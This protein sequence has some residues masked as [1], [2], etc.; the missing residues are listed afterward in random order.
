MNSDAFVADFAHVAQ[1]QQSRRARLR[2]HRDGGA[3][4][5]GIGVVGIVDDGAPRRPAFTCSRPATARNAASPSRRPPALAP[6]R[7]AAAAAAER[8]RRVVPS[9]H[10]AARRSTLPCGVASSRTLPQTSCDSARSPPPAP[11]RPNSRTDDASPSALRRATTS[12]QKDAK[13]SS[14]LMTA[15]PRTRQA[16]SNQRGVLGGDVGDAL[17]ELL[18]LALRV[19]DDADRRAARS[20]RASAV[21]PG[22]FMPI[23]MTAARCS[24]RSRSSVSGR[25]MS[26][27]RLPRVASTLRRAEMRA[28][29]RRDHLLD[30]RLAV[31][32]DDGGQRHRRIAAARMRQA[33]RA[34]AAG[35]GTVDAA[36]RG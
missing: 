14:A 7:S 4:R 22:W 8:I 17:H 25:P 15:T 20:Q 36:C 19:V 12:R 24:A 35:L 6:A 3:H 33:L 21:S 11:A 2:Q 29:D 5:I 16:Q 27:L 30:R 32:A 9:R 23:S 10:A 18:V 31:A 1:H 26:L 13:S 34:R 28:Q